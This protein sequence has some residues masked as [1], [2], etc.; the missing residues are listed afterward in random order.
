MT[1]SDNYIK[2]NKN[3]FI[4]YNPVLVKLIKPHKK[5]NKDYQ[6]SY[7]INIDKITVPAVKKTPSE[8]MKTKLPIFTYKFYSIRIVLKN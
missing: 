8:N 6:S 2:C 4:L 5:V 1:R 3:L 7:E